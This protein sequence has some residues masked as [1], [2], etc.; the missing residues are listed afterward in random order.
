MLHKTEINL[1]VQSRGTS[2]L[3]AT[4]LAKVKSEVYERQYERFYVQRP[5]RLVA[6]RPCLTG[7][8]MRSAEIID[9]SQGGASFLVGTTIGLPLHYYLNILGLA[10]RIGCAEVYRTNENRVGVKF[11]N[12]L[13]PET[14]RLV[15]RADFMIGN[16]EANAARKM[17]R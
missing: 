7:V 8:S 10:Y 14:L 5:A 3:N 12:L 1:V 13:T 15:V 4:H 6:V 17:R 11:I 2:M 9:I 16:A